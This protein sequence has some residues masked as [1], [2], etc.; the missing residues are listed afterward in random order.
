[1][2]RVNFSSFLLAVLMTAAVPCSGIAQQTAQTIFH[3]G[4]ILT[5]AG[6]TPAYVEALAVK[7]GII[8]FAGPMDGALA[9]VTASMK[10]SGGSC[11]PSY[12]AA[13]TAAGVWTGMGRDSGG[14]EFAVSRRSA[15]M[16]ASARSDKAVIVN[17]GLTPSERGMIE[18][19]I[20]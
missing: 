18:P 13:I 6:D 15:I 8:A 2:G 10:T 7:D 12:R 14:S 11:N 19:S 16:W 1:M 3:G 4:R 9:L 5:M 17:S 20:T